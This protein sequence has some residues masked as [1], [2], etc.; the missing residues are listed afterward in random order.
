MLKGLS[1]DEGCEGRNDENSRSPVGMAGH[2]LNDLA[3]N[4]ITNQG[5]GLALGHQIPRQLRWGLL[6]RQVAHIPHHN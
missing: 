6:G 3:I 1:Q 5:C 2:L 4:L